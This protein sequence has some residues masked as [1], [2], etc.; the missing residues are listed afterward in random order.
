MRLL[1]TSRPKPTSTGG[2]GGYSI[3]LPGID[4][5]LKREDAEAIVNASGGRRLASCND[6]TCCPRG[7][8]DMIKDPKGH[9]LR[10]R[11]MQCD[12]IS[13]VPEPLRPKHFLD[14][15]LTEADR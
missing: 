15:S 5:L 9:F 12:A 1:G 11:A 2:G 10:Q 6:R 14:K 7:F 4:R 3:L 13:A 8:E